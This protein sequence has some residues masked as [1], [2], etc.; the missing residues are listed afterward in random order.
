MR[1]QCLPFPLSALD[2]FNNTFL[3]DRLNELSDLNDSV[4]ILI[5]IPQNK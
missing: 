2:F 3:N 5:G 4:S 1:N